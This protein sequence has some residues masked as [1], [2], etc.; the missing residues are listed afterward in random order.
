MQE[1]NRR[2][3]ILCQMIVSLER[4]DSRVNTAQI[5][6]PYI[7]EFE[8]LGKPTPAHLTNRLSFTLE[9]SPS[10][11]GWRRSSGRRAAGWFQSPLPR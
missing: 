7:L 3:E 2:P 6:V 8:V 10:A 9:G 1:G 5:W 4:T 11:S